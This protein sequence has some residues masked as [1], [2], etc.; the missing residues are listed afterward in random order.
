[1]GGTWNAT[2]HQFTVS[3]TQPGSAGTPVSID[4]SQEQRVLVSDIASGE[5]IGAS[6]L[7]ATTSTPITFTASLVSGATLTSL[8]GL[9]GSGESVASA[10]ACSATGY[11]SGNPAYLSFSGVGNG[12]GYYR[13]GL[14]V[15][16]YSG[17]SLDAV[18]GERP[19]L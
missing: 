1:M 11:A 8:T 9:L 15:W 7:A 2:N 14:E 16:S 12:G 19:H 3:A 10:W 5:S 17:G 13:D 4:L 18:F 6:F